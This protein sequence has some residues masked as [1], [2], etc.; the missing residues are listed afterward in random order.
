VQVAQ[1]QVLLRQIGV[2]LVVVLV[3]L[4]QMLSENHLEVVPLL[5]VVLLEKLAK[6]TQ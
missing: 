2:V 3:D 4:G 5:R 6:I 1:I